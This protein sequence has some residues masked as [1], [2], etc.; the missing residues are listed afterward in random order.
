MTSNTDN[1][2]S[3]TTASKKVPRVLLEEGMHYESN[4]LML[5]PGCIMSRMDSSGCSGDFVGKK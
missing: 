4:G 3:S 2:L 5:V 1:T